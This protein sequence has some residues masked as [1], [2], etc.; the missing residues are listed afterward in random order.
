MCGSV[1]WIVPA[2]PRSVAPTR[3]PRGA[4]GLR[5]CGGRSRADAAVIEDHFHEDGTV[6]DVLYV[7]IPQFLE[8]LDGDRS[9][10]NHDSLALLIPH[11]IL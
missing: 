1:S 4:A 11:K 9:G 7:H 10:L 8:E 3:R 2:G 5:V 6:G